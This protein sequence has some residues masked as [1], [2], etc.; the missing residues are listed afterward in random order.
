MILSEQQ[1]RWCEIQFYYFCLDI[2]NIHKDM[3][4][5][6]L[7]VEVIANI[8]HL[9]YKMLKRL[10]G[11]MLGDPYY[12]PVKE[13]IISLA[14]AYGCKA[15]N[16]CKDL[17]IARQTVYNVLK[18]PNRNTI[19]HSTP[20]LRIN[21]DQELQKFCNILPMIQKAGIHAPTN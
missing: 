15:T 20:L 11:I 5:V 18:N 21:E 16:I 1:R 4:E 3:I 10:A 13:E 9:D 2:Y 6:V 7:M 17:N 8:G 12:L 14:H 19:T